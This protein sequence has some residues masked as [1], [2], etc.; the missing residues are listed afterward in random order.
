MR[1]ITIYI[2][3]III[4]I[5]IIYAICV[6]RL[7]NFQFW[8]YLDGR[9]LKDCT[10]PKDIKKFL[11]DVHDFTEDL[12]GEDIF[13]MF[14]PYV[15]VRSLKEKKNWMDVWKKIPNDSWCTGYTINPLLSPPPWNKPPLPFQGKKVIK[16][17]PPSMK[18]PLP[19]PNFSLLIY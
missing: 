2:I 17:P 12:P 1:L 16:P 9:D 10:L 19:S 8:F 7:R 14:H 15:T 13:P 11:V 6:R 5:I 4:I 3:I 18:P